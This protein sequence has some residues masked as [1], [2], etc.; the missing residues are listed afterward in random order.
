MLPLSV[1]ELSGCSSLTEKKRQRHTH[2][3]A[4]QYLKV[5]LGGLSSLIHGQASSHAL[6]AVILTVLDKPYMQHIILTMFYVT[7]QCKGQHKL[8]F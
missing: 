8:I 3:Y 6:R 2:A 7:M 4:M 1:D 5:N